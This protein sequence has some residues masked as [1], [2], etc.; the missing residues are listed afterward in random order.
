MIN[1]ASLLKLRAMKKTFQKEHPKF[2]LFLNALGKNGLTEGSII[3]IDVDMPDGRRMSSNLK[4]T[5]N[6][7]AAYQ[8]VMQIIQ[9]QN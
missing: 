2:L 7:I 4:L 5:A 3:S 6:D 8:E 1:P 9:E